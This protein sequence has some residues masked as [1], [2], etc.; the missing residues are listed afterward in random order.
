[1][2]SFHIYKLEVVETTTAQVEQ[3]NKNGLLQNKWVGGTLIWMAQDTCATTF[4][5]LLCKI[6]D[7]FLVYGNIS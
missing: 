7:R 4:E 3:K 1:M 5:E 6:E 2:S